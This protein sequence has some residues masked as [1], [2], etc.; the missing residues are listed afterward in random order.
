MDKCLKAGLRDESV[1]PESF[2]DLVFRDRVRP[3]LEEKQQQIKCF[4]SEMYD[5]C[6]RRS[7]AG[8]S[9]DPYATEVIFH[10]PPPALSLPHGHDRMAKALSTNTRLN[11]GPRDLSSSEPSCS[12][13][14]ADHA[15]LR[16][17]FDFPH[18]ADQWVPT[19]ESLGHQYLFRK[20]TSRHTHPAP[21]E[22]CATLDFAQVR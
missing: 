2:I 3:A 22:I 20:A 13:C 18:P 4:S 14:R 10:L 8:V 15:R 11:A 12:D 21:G 1:R 5:A 16:K 6:G 19:G 7:R 9:V 17:R